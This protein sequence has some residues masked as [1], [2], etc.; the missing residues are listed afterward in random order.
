[1]GEIVA[2]KFVDLIEII[3]KIIILITLIEFV[4]LCGIIKSIINSI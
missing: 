4:P 1:M 3:N 2:R